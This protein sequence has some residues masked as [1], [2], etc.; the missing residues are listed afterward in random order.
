MRSNG[1]WDGRVSDCIGNK[2]T[3]VGERYWKTQVSSGTSYNREAR[4]V[5]GGWVVDTDKK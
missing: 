1:C 2:K 5:S 3:G 4:G